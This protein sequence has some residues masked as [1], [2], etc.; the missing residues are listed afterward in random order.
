MKASL[1]RKRWA[2]PL[3]CVAAYAVCLILLL[4]RLALNLDETLDLATLRS[5]GWRELMTHIAYN[6]GV[7]PLGYL[8]RLPLV[9]WFGE[10]RA[11]ARL[12]SALF[13]VAGCCGVFLLARRVGLRWPLL[14]A[15]IFAAFPLQFRY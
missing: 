1:V 8:V 13:S 5:H 6:A 15:L 10:S 14:A 4:P 9:R 3:C 2:G 7:A 12:P 11:T